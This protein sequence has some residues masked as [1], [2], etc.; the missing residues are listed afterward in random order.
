MLNW[1]GKQWKAIGDR[2]EEMATLRGMLRSS[3]AKNVRLKEHLVV[4]ERRMTDLERF[5]ND[6]VILRRV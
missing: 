5:V 4:L 3:E 2:N 1:I 6:C